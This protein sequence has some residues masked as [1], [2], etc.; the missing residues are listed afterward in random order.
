MKTT[1]ILL[2]LATLAAAGAIAVGSGATFT[3]TS[4]NTISSVT[5]GTLTQ[6]NSKAGEAIFTATGIKPGDKVSG[7]LTIKNTGSLPAKF[8]LTEVKSVNGFT[9]KNLQ[10]TITNTTTNKQVWTGTFGEL[11]DGTKTELGVVASQAS[12]TYAFSADLNK[13][14]DNNNQNKTASATF[15]WDSVQA[16]DAAAASN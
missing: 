10:L 11:V 12:N 1:K 14:A 3:S 9:D 13:D 15:Q 6:E 8:S 7:S 16:D 2:P 4:A 5:S